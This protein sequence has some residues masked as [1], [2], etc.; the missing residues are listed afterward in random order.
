MRRGRQHVSTL[1]AVSG[2]ARILSARGRR[3]LW[4]VG[5]AWRV[6]ASLLPLA[7]GALSSCADRQVSVGYRPDPTLAR[8]TAPDALTIFD[9]GD[10][11]GSEGD[12]DVFRVGG[13]YVGFTTRVVKVMTDTP[14]P[15]S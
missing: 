13:I 11:R 6:G 12:H 1:E 9:F 8:L 10:Q 5:R 4:R 3:P 7:W 2:S 14:W 15:R